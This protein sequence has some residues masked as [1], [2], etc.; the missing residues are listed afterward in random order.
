MIVAVLARLV[1]T[2]LAFAAAARLLSGVHVHGGL[3]GYLVIAVVFGLVNAFI[4]TILRILTFPLKLLT[5]GLFSIIVNAL[6]LKITDA[7]TSH[8]QIDTFFWN[9]V[10]AAVIISVVSVVLDFILD[11]A[12]GRSGRRGNRRARARH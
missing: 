7:L 9:A 10:W 6:L 3:W 4:G 5:L 8:L 2:G 11:A 12:L 1:I